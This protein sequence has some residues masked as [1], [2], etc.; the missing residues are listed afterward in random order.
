MIDKYAGIFIKEFIGNDNLNLWGL[1]VD[2]Y[3]VDDYTIEIEAHLIKNEKINNLF[4]EYF[5]VLVKNRDDFL[6]VFDQEI[7]D[8][9]L[10][11][12]NFDFLQEY[13]EDILVS[14]ESNTRANWVMF[15]ADND[16]L[17]YMDIG[18]IYNF[19]LNDKVV[20]IDKV[21]SLR[22]KVKEVL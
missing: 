8:D 18:F 16:L 10:K 3:S 1:I 7:T 19:N 4:D 22:K 11:Q 14:A 12:I 13:M 5:N 2:S 17:D 20:D 21:R 15:C 9:V 6:R